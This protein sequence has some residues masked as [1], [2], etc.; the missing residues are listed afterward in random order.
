MDKEFWLSLNLDH[1]DISQAITYIRE[2]YAK[3]SIEEMAEH[4]NVNKGTLS[5]YENNPDSKP[6]VGILNR[7]CEA[8]GL[9]AKIFIT[10]KKKDK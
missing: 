6:G 9:E 4:M 7:T 8:C 1:R 3:K 2:K 5:A 10:S